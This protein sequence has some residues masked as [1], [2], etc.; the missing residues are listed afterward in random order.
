WRKMVSMENVEVANYISNT[1]LFKLARYTHNKPLY[2]ELMTFKNSAVGTG[3]MDFPITY[4]ENGKSV[5]T[6]LHQLNLADNYLL[7]FWSST[8]SHCLN[9][10]PKLKTFID[11]HPKNMKVIAFA[12]EDSKDNWEKTIPQFPDFIHVLGLE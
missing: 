2:K 6:S 11:E 3:A 5:N 12:L 9:E 7:I 10:L 8:C 4:D 1:Y